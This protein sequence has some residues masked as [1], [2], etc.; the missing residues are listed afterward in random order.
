MEGL[1]KIHLA[2]SY[3]YIFKKKL[4]YINSFVS[5]TIVSFLTWW[6][7]SNLAQEALQL[8]SKTPSRSV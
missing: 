7:N 4:S 1:N 8:L 5:N 6:Y 2:T 3:L